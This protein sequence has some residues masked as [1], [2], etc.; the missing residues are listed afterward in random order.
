MTKHLLKMLDLSPDDIYE[1][2]NLADQLKYDQRHGIPHRLLEGK[3]LVTIYEKRSTRTRISFETGMFQLGGLAMYL[4]GKESQVGRGEPMEDTAR[5]L[6][7]Y[8]DGIMMRTFRQ[9]DLEQLA[10]YATVPVINGMTDFSH[11]CQVLADLM[12]IRERYAHLDGLKLAYIGDG[13]NMCHSLTVGGLKCG[14]EVAVA[15]PHDYRPRQEVL[16]FAASDPEF[17][18]TLTEDPREAVKDADVVFTDVW[19]SMGKEDEAEERR[20]AFQGFQ[21]DDELLTLAAPGCMVQHCL[22]AHRGE[23]IT[24]QVFEAHADEIFDEAENRLHVQKA[25][26]CLLLGAKSEED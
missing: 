18:F 2:L 16:D 7:R 8:C 24:A 10:R 6:S 1:I 12:T 4:S 21:V 23:E 11:P 17:A 26:M 5:T 14:M 25:I 22:P 9:E 13:D 19:V 20:K 15:T 3:T